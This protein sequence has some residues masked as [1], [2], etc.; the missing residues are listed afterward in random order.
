M[1]RA[2]I[3]GCGNPLRSDD[4]FGCR[5]AEKLAACR[6]GSDLLDSHFL[7]S[8]VELLIR[9]Q[10][11]PDLAETASHFPLVIFIDAAVD[12][13]PGKLRCEKITRS[14]NNQQPGATSFSHSLTPES[15]IAWTAELYTKFPEAY[16]ISVG[17]ESFTEGESISP[18]VQAAFEPVLAQVR[19]LLARG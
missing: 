12:L 10:L 4:G 3:I 16:C 14:G 19:S 9:H 13:P 7:D 2:L 11:T 15:V 8:D 1:A 18:A 17:G 5:A 6:H